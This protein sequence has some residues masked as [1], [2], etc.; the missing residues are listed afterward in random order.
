MREFDGGT[1]SWLAW[2][3]NSRATG[4]RYINCDINVTASSGN[5]TLFLNLLYANQ[6]LE[7]M[8]TTADIFILLG[9]VKRK[10]FESTPHI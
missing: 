6:Q 7:R 3:E 10:V 4:E 1:K 2:V 9:Q 8:F 5:S